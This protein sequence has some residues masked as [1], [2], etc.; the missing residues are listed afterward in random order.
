[1][2]RTLFTQ[3]LLWQHRRPLPP[4]RPGHFRDHLLRRLDRSNARQVTIFRRMSGRFPWHG[5]GWFW[6]WMYAPYFEQLRQENENYK[7]TLGFSEF[8]RYG[9]RE[10][11]LRRKILP[12]DMLRD[13]ELQ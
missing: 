3:F 4:A 11:A 5:L 9:M 2:I 13:V 10:Q 6:R 12:P 1:M 7:K 8:I